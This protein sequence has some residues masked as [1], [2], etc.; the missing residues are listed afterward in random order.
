MIFPTSYS[1][2]SPTGL[3]IGEALAVQWVDCGLDEGTVEVRATVLRLR[4]ERA[5]YQ[6]V[7]KVRRLDGAS[8]SCRAG[9]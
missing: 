4:A 7:P 8:S 2:W 3:R 9:R 5:R 1:S 6:S